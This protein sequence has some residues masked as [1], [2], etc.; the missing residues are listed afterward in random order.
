[1]KT[2]VKELQTEGGRE[3][4]AVA[5][6][7]VGRRAQDGNQRGR[8]EAHDTF[9]RSLARSLGRKRRRGKYRRG[10]VGLPVGPAKPKLS[11]GQPGRSERGGRGL[12]GG[13]KGR[14]GADV[15]EARG[16]AIEERKDGRTGG[17]SEG[18]GSGAGVPPVAGPEILLRSVGAGGGSADGR[19]EPLLLF[20]HG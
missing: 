13:R 4:T 18:S 8:T 9:A 1:M 7:G 11:G 10:A 5:C 14:K 16:R 20:A 6:P 3:S 19:R 17:E 15:N 2:T 12:R